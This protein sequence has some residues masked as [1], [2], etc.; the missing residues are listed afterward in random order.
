[1]GPSEGQAGQGIYDV[2]I[3]G[4]GFAGVT[5]AR[6]LRH[7]GRTVLLLEARDRLGGR[8]W[9]KAN[10]FK[11][12]PLEMG[13][14]WIDSRERYAWAEAHRYGLT[15]TKP[16]AGA[17]PSTWLVQVQLR[18]G[19][20]PIP[21]DELRDVERLMIA[22]NQAASRVTLDQPLADQGLTDLDISLSDFL[23]QLQLPSATRDIAGLK[24]RRYGSASEGNIS[25]LHLIRRI[26]AAGSVS[27]LIMSASGYRLKAG[28]A[29]L[30]RAIADDA[31]ADVRLSTPV[32]SIRQ[33]DSGV[34][35]ETAAGV[36]H[37]HTAIVA[38]PLGV[39]KHIEFHP[40]L[41]IGKRRLS[42]EELACVGVKVWAVVRGAP[43]DFFAVG[44]GAGLDWLESEGTVIGDG[45]LMA[46]YGSDATVLDNRDRAALQRA[47][48]SFLPDA[49]VLAICGHDW[50]HDPYSLET[51]AVFRPGQ[52]SRDERQLIGRTNL[53][54]R[55]VF[56]RHVKQASSFKEKGKRLQVHPWETNDMHR[57]SG[58]SRL[59]RSW[60][61]SLSVL[62]LSVCKHQRPGANSYITPSI[63]QWRPRRSL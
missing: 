49:E 17:W 60:Q 35:A 61:P 15:L 48:R 23:D 52:I 12:V 54:S 10:G 51:W 13:G 8:A 47:V 14:A 40:A 34:A 32:R 33:D 21:V 11:D 50:R 41:N 27:E 1:M 56:A 28:T 38:V 7:Q 22:L 29:A 30:V 5:A 44:R 18:H 59:R 42:M 63:R 55:A 45:V 6:E 2:L 46:G 36:F 31:N 24:L 57:K 25:A 20:L 19:V 16:A 39:L 37:G 3:V 43:R 62:H 53:L 58:T 26:A 9:F 4:G